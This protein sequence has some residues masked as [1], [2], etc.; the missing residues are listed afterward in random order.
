ME[1]FIVYFLFDKNKAMRERNEW[2]HQVDHMQLIVDRKFH[3]RYRPYLHCGLTDIVKLFLFV[4]RVPLIWFA[5]SFRYNEKLVTYCKKKNCCPKYYLYICLF[6]RTK[7]FYVHS[8]NFINIAV[9]L[10]IRLL[11]FLTM[12]Y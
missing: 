3:A 11:R 4:R 1:F 6:N 2:S 8:I 7:A 5:I 10:F 9:L 12:F